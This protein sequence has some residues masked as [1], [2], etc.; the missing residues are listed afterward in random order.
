MAAAAVEEAALLTESETV[1]DSAKRARMTLKL[2][3][4]L[5][6]R[7]KRRLKVAAKKEE[8][9]KANAQAKMPEVAREKDDDHEAVKKFDL[10]LKTSDS[11]TLLIKVT[12]QLSKYKE[13]CSLVLQ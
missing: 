11:F 7:R 3:A 6:S 1:R 4:K 2:V 5:D 13:R 12:K 8:L 10:K 9:R